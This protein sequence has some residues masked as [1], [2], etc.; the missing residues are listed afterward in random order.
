[1]PDSLR[2]LAALGVNLDDC[3]SAPFRGIRFLGAEAAVAAD[4]P[5]GSGLGIRRTL[6]HERM[7]QAAIAAGVEIEWGAHVKLADEHCLLNAT[8]VH[9]R[10]TIGADGQNSR[11]RGW[12][13]LSNGRDYQR[14]IGLRRHFQTAPWSEHVEIY[15]GNENQ[16]YVTPIS[17]GEVCVALISHCRLESFEAALERHPTLHARLRGARY[18]AVKG[19]VTVSRRLRAVTRGRVALIGEASGSADAITG[20]GLAM[21]FRQAEALGEALAVSDLRR[22]EAAHRRIVRLPQLMGR[23]M[24]LMDRSGWLRRRALRAFA[25]RPERF[26]QMLS[27]HVGETPVAQFARSN[28]AGFGWELLKA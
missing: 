5:N 21:C 13:G 28:L 16:F 3:P 18:T 12:A 2:A 23:S 8:R 7:V 15:W 17:S 11:V 10:W 9:S 4:F 20:E 6:L 14:R 27:V 1:M 25:A 26:A 19:A 24:L 22:Y